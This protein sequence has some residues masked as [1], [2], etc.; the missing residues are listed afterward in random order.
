MALSRMEIPTHNTQTRHRQQRPDRCRRVDAQPITS[1]PHGRSTTRAADRRRPTSA[2]FASLSLLLAAYLCLWVQGAAGA[3]ASLTLRVRMPDGAVKRVK[4]TATDTAD[5]I[6]SKLGM[7]DGGSGGGEGLSTD[8]GAG[9]VVDGS[10]SVAA[11]GLGNGDFLYVKSDSAARSA[12]K[13]KLEALERMKSAVGAKATGNKFVPFPDH[14]RPPPP[15]VTKRVKNWQDLEAMQAQTFSL[16]PQKDSN[17]KKISVE[18]SAMDDFVGYLKQTGLGRHRCALLFGRVSP[19]TNGIKVEAMYEPPQEEHSRGTGTYDSSALTEAARVAVATAAARDKDGGGGSGGGGSETCEAQ[20]A[21]AAEVARAVRVAELLGLRLVGWC[22]SHDKREHF[23]AATDVVTAAALQLMSMA[24]RGKEEGVLVATVTVPVNATSGEVATEAFSV[25]NQTVQM[26]SEGIFASDQPD[27]TADRV[28]TTAVVKEGG[29]ETKTPETLGLICNV[30]IVQHKGKLQTR[31]PSSNR[32]SKAAPFLSDLKE[33]LFG[34]IEP[35][36]T[37]AQTKKKKKPKQPSFLNRLSDFQLLVFLSRQM[38][39]SRDFEELC[40]VVGKG[41]GKSPVLDKLKECY[42]DAMNAADEHGIIHPGTCPSPIN[43]TKRPNN[44]AKD[45]MRSNGNGD[46]STPAV[47]TTTPAP[48]DDSPLKSKPMADSQPSSST[49]RSEAP[50]AGGGGRDGG[51]SEAVG[52]DKKEALVA[53]GGVP[54]SQAAGEVVRPILLSALQELSELARPE[55]AASAVVAGACKAINVRRAALFKVVDEQGTLQEIGAGTSNQRVVEPG[56]GLVGQVAA[57]GIAPAAQEGSGVDGSGI[58]VTSDPSKEK[59]FAAEFDL[60]RGEEPAGDSTSAMICGPVKD[61]SG[62]MWG[63]LVVTEPL[64][65]G[66]FD[67][68]SVGTFRAVSTMGAV[69]MRNSEMFW[70]GEMGCEKFRNMMEVIEATNATLGVNHLLYTIAKCLPVICEAQKCTCFLVDDDKDELWVVQGE[71]N[72]RVP[73]SKGIAGAVATSGNVENISDVY[74]DP[75][76]N[77]EVDLETGFQTHSIL[78]MPVRGGEENKVIAV[79]QLINKQGKLLD[80]GRRDS[81]TGMHFTSQDVAVIGAFLSLLGPHIFKS[82]MLHPKRKMN[83]RVNKVG[84]DEEAISERQGL[85]MARRQKSM[86]SLFGGLDPG[87]SFEEDE[88]DEGDDN[89]DGID[90]DND[91]TSRGSLESN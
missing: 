64:S 27:P 59:P 2:T 78:A 55:I 70:R 39:F 32:A 6:M 42:D 38:G 50:D 65:G 60:P 79:V 30:A 66:A 1:P 75:R 82:S 68:E 91:G 22:L 17:V 21:A 13:A 20:G 24:E 74:A 90:N 83:I 77:K 26:F 11:L 46:D 35:P 4:A 67:E 81:C 86:G 7:A 40:A 29:K 80:G 58:L 37:N 49:A 88:E 23:M 69:S 9:G 33:A 36:K 25:S 87:Q 53:G 52:L 71:V 84:G 3:G 44:A 47:E 57:A 14:A 10:A 34:A 89:D 63:V 8:A 73:K 48:S 28:T 76:F 61:G 72:I 51:D 41:D 62:E 12:A 5:G 56:K 85:E 43:A 15:R 16:K 19:S 31:F 54:V 18:E 45:T